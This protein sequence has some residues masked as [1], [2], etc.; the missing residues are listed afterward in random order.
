MINRNFPCLGSATLRE[1]TNREHIF[2]NRADKIYS[3]HDFKGPSHEN[4]KIRDRQFITVVKKNGKN[5]EM[6]Q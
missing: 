4:N 6:M 1:T 5:T 3:V 2:W